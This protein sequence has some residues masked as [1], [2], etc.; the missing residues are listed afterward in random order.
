MTSEPYRL[1]S[2]T[3][4]EKWEPPPWLINGVLSK[5]A[6]GA[7]Y[8]EPGVGK[9]FLA[10]DWS[11]SIGLGLP[12][13]GLETAQGLVVYIAAEGG[14]SISTRVRAWKAV[15]EI[16]GS[17]NVY[18]LPEAVLLRDFKNRAS[19][20]M[21][22]MRLS[23][24]PDLIV[25]DTLARTLVGADENSAKEVGEYI[26]AVD[27][28][29][30]ET[31]AAVLLV[32]HIGKNSIRGERGSSALRGAADTMMSLTLSKQPSAFTLECTKQK[33]A[34]EFDKINLGLKTVDLGGG[35]SSCVI[36]AGDA[37]VDKGELSAPQR[38][39]LNT[40]SQFGTK[41]ATSGE[42]LE[43]TKRSQSTFYR[44]LREL[45]SGGFVQRPALKKKSERYRLTEKGCDAITST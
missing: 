10:L 21:A 28:I 29:R 27:L 2:D 7:M 15:N 20:M 11:L 31:R 4:I 26:A 37:H 8:G 38:M 12:W 24:L 17:A 25:I 9:T 33:D 39:A 16:K 30:K 13:Q 6:F 34:R 44:A 14:F 32:H 45:E 19:L 3:E 22:L 43:A 18:F 42:W 5:G 36:V 41:G 35:E 1:Y 23:P 40:L